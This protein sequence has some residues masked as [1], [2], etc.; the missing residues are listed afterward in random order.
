[1]TVHVGVN[2]GYGKFRICLN[3]QKRL[4][5][6]R[7]GLA[8]QPLGDPLGVTATFWSAGEGSVI[9]MVSIIALF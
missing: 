5:F 7:Q 8:F 1:M 3:G 2:I 4:E 9:E 6:Q